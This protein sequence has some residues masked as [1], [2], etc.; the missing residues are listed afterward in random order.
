MV[1]ASLAEAAE[2]GFGC[3]LALWEPVT[4]VRGV[5]GLDAGTWGVVVGWTGAAYSVR[6]GA[7]RDGEAVTVVVSAEFLGPRVCAPCAGAE[8]LEATEVSF[9]DSD[10]GRCKLCDGNAR[11]TLVSPL[12][13]CC[14]ASV[15]AGCANDLEAHG[16]A[17]LCPHCGASADDP[18][19]EVTATRARRYAKRGDPRAFYGLAAL[20]G[21]V[22]GV[23]EASAHLLALVER[24]YGE[25]ILAYANACA[26]NGFVADG[27]R[28][29]FAAANLG[30]ADAC[31]QLAN[32][33][34]HGDAP[35]FGAPP[36]MERA[37]D[38][39]GQAAD[40]GC[41]E[42]AHARSGA[43][44]GGDSATDRPTR[45]CRAIVCFEGSIRTSSQL[46]RETIARAERSGN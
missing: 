28:W 21:V 23:A 37:R 14:G 10:F 45:E 20:D 46:R 18:Q 30:N 6:T 34:A 3:E 19:L 35:I 8:K 17:A 43:G 2:V 26:C 40:R 44:E 25:A 41:A 12:Y 16:V 9:G 42:A 22:V 13:L 24:G 31:H 36:S 39:Y 29:W 7:F 38:L 33:N 4:L 15:C 32:A 5:D 1:M 11:L 27:L